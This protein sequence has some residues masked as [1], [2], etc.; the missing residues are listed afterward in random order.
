MRRVSTNVVTRHL[1]TGKTARSIEASRQ[2]RSI[3]L[4]D[5]RCQRLVEGKRVAEESA[6]WV[7]SVG[8]LLTGGDTGRD[9]DRTRPLRSGQDGLNQV[10]GD[11]GQAEVAPLEG[12]GE[13]LVVDAQEV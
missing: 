12:K 11:V 3:C 2:A 6:S 7:G 4:E 10:A 13:P 1:S 5:F 8:S 9:G